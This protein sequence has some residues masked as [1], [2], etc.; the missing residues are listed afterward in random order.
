MAGN[1]TS[2]I[3][4]S[5][6]PNTA[7]FSAHYVDDLAGSGI[8][9]TFT[10]NDCIISSDYLVYSTETSMSGGNN[11]TITAYNHQYIKNNINDNIIITLPTQDLYAWVCVEST[12]M[13][14][15]MVGTVTYTKT[16]PE[17]G[18]STRTCGDDGVYT[19]MGTIN[20]TSEN[21]GVS[22][23]FGFQ[24]TYN[25][26]SSKDILIN[27]PKYISNLSNGTDTYIIK[28]AEAR[29]SLA[30]KQDIL[31]S[32]TNI[33]TINNTSILGSGNIST[34]E[35][36]SQS[37]NNGKFLTTNGSSASWA[38]V[39][40]PTVDQTYSS[41][42][43]STN[44]LSHK[45][46]ADAKFL[47]NTATGTNSITILGTATAN[48][49]AI[50]IGYLSSAAG[51]SVAL[52]KQVTASGIDS[53]AIGEITEATEIYT[54]AIGASAHSTAT[55]AIQLGGQG[56]N[57]EA[58]SFY[59]ATDWNKN[60]K[61]LGSDGKIPDDRLNTTIARTSQIPTT[62][63]QLTNNS[64]FIT[65]ISWGDITGTLSS[66]SD[67]NT[68]LN[69]KAN[70][71]SVVHLSGDET[72]NGGKTFNQAFIIGTT[73]THPN[74]GGQLI[75]KKSHNST[76]AG[77]VIVDQNVNNLR[78]IGQSTSLGIIVPFYIDCENNKVYTATPATGDNST[79]VATTAFVKAQGY[80]TTSQ[81][82]TI[83][84]TYS[85][86]SA[87]A[88]SG[89]AVASAISS[90]ISSV[91]K[92]AGSVVFANLP[93]PSASNEGN[94][95]NVT[96]AFT[97]TS[98]FVE[99]AGINYPAG[100]NVVI[101]NTGSNTY[102]FDTLTGA[103]QP[104]LISGTNIKTINSNSILGS[105]NLDIDALP[106]QTNNS[107]KFLT[108]NGTTASWSNVIIPFGEST[109]AA[110]AVQ[111]EVTISEI[112]ELK[113]GQ[114][115]I[116]KPTITSTVADATLKLNNFT[117]YPMLYGAAAIT[118]STDSITWAANYPSWF[119]FDGSNWV[120]LGHGVDNNTTYSAMSVAE[121]T[122]GTK[123][124]ARSV[125]ADY[126]KQIIQGTTLTGLSTST[127]SAVTEADTV[128][129]GIGKLQA[130]VNN[131]VDKTSI[132]TTSTA[133]LVKPDGTSITIDSNGT[134]S[135]AGGSAYAM[136]IVDYTEEDE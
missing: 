101:I 12:F 95:Y 60:W 133:G 1:P 6:Y 32:G 56:T 42:S 103:F 126:L 63:S 45:A 16:I 44:A 80:A 85:A 31:V 71:S 129:T 26:D 19:D 22:S 28:D 132:A 99:G 107:G 81:I 46:I 118:T 59:V 78:V 14:E 127:N 117:A 92:P 27:L 111:K 106:S 90:A 110:D 20:R 25:R 131:K 64:G 123:T 93:T 124:T 39:S 102:K 7:I 125:R 79:Q 119:R 70:D 74:E 134:I 98:N 9:I 29:S 122:T 30:N 15:T 91:Y 105:G 5:I 115:I 88:Q 37:G 87:N 21:V 66:Q 8:D 4:I 13:P 11:L 55:R 94:V 17:I 73:E 38:T 23:G 82:P 135:A 34:S 112:T 96:N 128:T 104:L 108:T 3:T 58:N 50:N 10:N 57:N 84:Q 76:M 68:A 36:P 75:F 62:T 43:T 40:I 53:I 97:T 89:V 18:S 83:D 67:L 113:T 120:F 47:Q 35:L 86:S 100:T 121:G 65:G 41:S 52:G 61:M 49:S 114:I 136:V 116:V 48:N 24:Y 130:Q 72:I 69:N 33:K 109:S 77:D 2:N 54:I 51:G